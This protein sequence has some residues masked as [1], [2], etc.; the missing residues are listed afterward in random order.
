MQKID[1]EKVVEELKE[2]I[3]KVGVKEFSKLT[4]VWQSTL[5]AFLSGDRV[6]SLEKCMEIIDRYEKAKK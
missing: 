2:L 1:K 3:R 6:W 5:Y 4:G